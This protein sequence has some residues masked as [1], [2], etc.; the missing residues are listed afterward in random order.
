MDIHNDTVALALAR[1]EARSAGRHE[2]T[3]TAAHTGD[4]AD[5]VFAEALRDDS[6]YELDWLWAYVHVSG[7]ARQRY[8]LERALAINPQSEMALRAL[9]SLQCSMSV[10][11]ET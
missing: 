5:D 9:A 6:N 11:R 7:V 2:R 8:C 3:D 1:A 10:K 4:R